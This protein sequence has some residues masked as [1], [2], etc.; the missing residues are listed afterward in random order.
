MQ[1]KTWENS[2][3]LQ[4]ISSTFHPGGDL[5][6]HT[7]VSEAGSMTT[8]P[9]R[10]GERG[11][12]TSVTR[13]IWEKIA[14]YVPQAIVVNINAYVYLTVGEKKPKMLATFV[15]FKN[16]PKVNN[17]PMGAKLRT[18]WLPWLQV[19]LFLSAELFWWNLRVAKMFS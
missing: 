8:T 7:F 10:Q 19:T 18:S 1:T 4:K 16:L 14:Q 17:H 5:N 9:R 13:W 15:I 3:A 12:A 11:I 6:P 2:I